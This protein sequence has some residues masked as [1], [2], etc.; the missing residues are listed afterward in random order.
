MKLILTA[1]YCVDKVADEFALIDE[2]RV[3]RREAQM[4]KLS[5]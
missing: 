2:Q 1:Y 3:G 5:G 4:T